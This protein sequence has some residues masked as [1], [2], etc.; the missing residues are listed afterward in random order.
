MRTC[1][2]KVNIENQASDETS[3]S[4]ILEEGDVDI[5]LF[6][7]VAERVQGAVGSAG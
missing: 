1:R 2:I 5:A 3:F 6:D 4:M 7:G